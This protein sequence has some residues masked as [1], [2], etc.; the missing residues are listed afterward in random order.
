MWILYVIFAGEPYCEPYIAMAVSENS[1]V[2]NSY[3]A[4][5]FVFQYVILQLKYQCVRSLLCVNQN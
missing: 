4:S 1:G 3:T 5:H 2:H